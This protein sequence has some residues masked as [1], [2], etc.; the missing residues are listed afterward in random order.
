MLDKVIKG[1]KGEEEAA[2]LLKKKGYKIIEKNYRCRFGEIDII[3]KD[4]GTLVFVEVKARTSDRF[5]TP[6]CG[7]DF[8]K[9]RHMTLASSCYIVE[10]GIGDLDVRF[11]VVSI[12][13]KNGGSSEIIKD[14]FEAVEFE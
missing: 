12:E 10:R 8:R 14:A 13:L 4:G 1:R 7:V 2:V 9:Q 11:D 3:A 5:G 6:K